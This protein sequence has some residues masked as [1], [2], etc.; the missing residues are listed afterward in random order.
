M[1]TKL[2]T[3]EKEMTSDILAH[4]LWNESEGMN[5]EQLKA[6]MKGILF[7]RQK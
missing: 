7:L 2:N 6:L 5:E 3:K 1:A 4:I